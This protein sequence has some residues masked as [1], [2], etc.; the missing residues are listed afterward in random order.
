MGT[1][2]LEFILV[3]RDRVSAQFRTQRLNVMNH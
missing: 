2:H 3:N 1:F